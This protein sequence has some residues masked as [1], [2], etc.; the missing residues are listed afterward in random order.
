MTTKDYSD[1][2]RYVIEAEEESQELDLEWLSQKY[3]IP[4]DELQ[5]VVQLFSRANFTFGNRQRQV[6]S[7]VAD[8]R[9]I[10][11]L[12][13]GNCGEVWQ[14]ETLNTRQTVAL[15]LIQIGS[16]NPTNK[17]TL[18]RFESETTALLRLTHPNIA[19]VL[20]PSP[21]DAEVPYIAME[22]L[23]GPPELPGQP[24]EA[25]TQYCH[26]KKLGLRERI[27]LLLP[28]CEALAYAHTE[29]IVHRDLKPSNILVAIQ[30]NMP[31]PK[32]IDFGLAKSFQAPLYDLTAADLT[33]E[34]VG[35]PM[36]M[37]P[38]QLSPKLRDKFKDSPSPD[39]F[40]LGVV[41]YEL[42]TGTTPL[43]ANDGEKLDQATVLAALRDSE[44]LPRPSEKMQLSRVAQDFSRHIGYR[45]DQLQSL[46]QRDLDWIVDR[47]IRKDPEERYPSVNALAKDLRNYLEHKPLQ[48]GPP[49]LAL[50]F[51][52]FYRRNQ[53]AVIAFAITMLSIFLG[54][55]GLSVGL[56]RA[57]QAASQAADSQQLAESVSNFLQEDLLQLTSVV[58]QIKSLGQRSPI[59]GKAAT[60]REL[61][62]RAAGKLKSNQSMNWKVKGEL[63][64]I[65]GV[66]YRNIG[67]YALAEEILRSAVEEFAKSTVPHDEKLLSA[68]AEWAFAQCEQGNFNGGL[69][70]LEAILKER[71]QSASGPT[72]GILET[73]VMLG[74]ACYR[75]TA[76]QDSMV[77]RQQALKMCEELLGKSAPETIICEN[78]VAESLHTLNKV[79]EA[80][81]EYERLQPIVDEKFG[82]SSM[83]SIHLINCRAVALREKSEVGKAIELLRE[84]AAGRLALLEV[85]HPLT[86][87]AQE[88]LA[89]ALRDAGQLDEAHRMLTAVLKHR[90]ETLT[91]KHPLTLST[92]IEL[93]VCEG[94]AGKLQLAIEQLSTI[95]CEAFAA[96][97]GT[98]EETLRARGNLGF[99]LGMN[100]QP[101]LA[102]GHFI[103][104]LPLYLKKY[105]LK[106]NDSLS[107]IQSLA[108]NG[109]KCGHAAQ[110]K[111]LL[112]QILLAPPSDTAAGD[113]V[114]KQIQAVIDSI[115][116]D[117]P[118]PSDSS[119]P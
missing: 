77:Y 88:N 116:P 18:A 39:I 104:L 103:E 7:I 111:E 107:C 73:L 49:S 23:E 60:L 114:L 66:S 93:A 59:I 24:A 4:L 26:R 61:L 42:V 3:S 62:D 74:D 50:R 48:V 83:E 33:T 19:K 100:D 90:R 5:N 70:T 64:R 9:L 110:V 21:D 109:P 10:R 15:K 81:R 71:Q 112:Q 113:D 11:K 41:L 69:E 17:G 44:E 96:L 65:V 29:S 16:S 6:G 108:T 105:G 117:Q 13:A 95:Y 36:Y 47:A 75:A 72:R 38:E 32:V 106:H 43:A 45:P 14:A 30:A 1:L 8:Y 58:G 98:Q 27:E 52:K 46:L 67:E 37:A 51:K 94:M 12:G 40:S 91:D 80:L 92:G 31:I 76:S 115:A 79:D 82:K 20:K 55:I 22:L 87:Q 34:F 119:V 68:K 118:L 53:V 57:R 84:V 35:T 99:A 54:M 85:N 101:E 2:F 97:G 102:F 56:L 28:I 25:I 89:V 78:R 63:L 86:I